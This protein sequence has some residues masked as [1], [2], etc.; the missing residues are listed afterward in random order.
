MTY[1]NVVKNQSDIDLHIHTTCSDGTYTPEQIIV[2]AHELKMTKIA[3]TDHDTVEAFSAE[4]LHLAT[5]Y[6]VLLI[7]GI[8]ISCTY[9]N[10][11]IHILGLNIDYQNSSLINILQ[12]YHRKKAKY[13]LRLCQELQKI[14]I[15][16][17]LDRKDYSLKSLVKVVQQKYQISKD[18]IMDKIKCLESFTKYKEANISVKQAL[19]IIHDCGGYSVLAHINQITEDKPRSEVII[20]DLKKEGLDGLEIYHPGYTK[21][22]CDYYLSLARKYSLLCSGGSDFHGTKR[23]NIALGGIEMLSNN[24]SILTKI[25]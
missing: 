9:Q 6:N 19:D 8:E 5:T 3:I 7:P 12:N 18:E 2:H 14:K 4:L 10:S 16:V 24:L 25:L 15:E 21:E 1:N 23:S 13:I 11:L 20:A 22:L 17:F